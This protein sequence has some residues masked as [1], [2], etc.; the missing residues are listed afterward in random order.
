MGGGFGWLTRKYGLALDNLLSAELVLANA[1]VAHLLPAGFPMPFG[2]PMQLIFPD[3]ITRAVEQ[4]FRDAGVEV[5]VGD[6]TNGDEFLARGGTVTFNGSASVNDTGLVTLRA[7]DQG[8][9]LVIGE[10]WTDITVKAAPSAGV[11]IARALD[12]VDRA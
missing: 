6:W 5:R 10:G 3:E 4:A 8:D 11:V 12:V 2:L 1:A 9:A 7:T